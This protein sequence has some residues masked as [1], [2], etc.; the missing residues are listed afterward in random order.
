VVESE[1]PAKSEVP[2]STAV[3]YE[4]FIPPQKYHRTSP[5]EF[6]TLS[7]EHQ[8]VYQE[9]LKHFAAEDFVIPGIEKGDGKLT[10]E[11]KYFLVSLCH[12]TPRDDGC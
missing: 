1:S 11:E 3:D 5:P 6:L 10:E 9:V 8:A 7:E 12:S 2:D 4:P